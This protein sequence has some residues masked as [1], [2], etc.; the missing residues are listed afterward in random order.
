MML[1]YNLTDRKKTI[2][3]PTTL[4]AACNTLTREQLRKEAYNKIILVFL[5]DRTFLKESS[6]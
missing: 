2:L 6:V 4:L 3:K 1:W 5:K